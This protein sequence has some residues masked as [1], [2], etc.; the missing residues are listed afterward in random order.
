MP[1]VMYMRP[2]QG[3]VEIVIPA[4]ESVGVVTIASAKLSEDGTRYKW[5][6]A[7]GVEWFADKPGRRSGGA[8]TLGDV[9]SDLQSKV[10]RHGVVLNG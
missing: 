8:E 3:V 5:E 1:K 2:K 9:I 4:A 10:D 6:L 7:E